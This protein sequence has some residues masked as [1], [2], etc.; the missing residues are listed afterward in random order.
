MQSFGKIAIWGAGDTCKKIIAMVKENQLGE[1]VAIADSDRR[2][3]GQL[4]SEGGRE[5]LSPIELQY[6]ILGKELQVDS[7]VF[8]IRNCFVE[9]ASAYF[10]FCDGVKGYMINPAIYFETTYDLS[11]GKDILL[12]IDFKKPRLDYLQIDLLQHCNMKCKSCMLYSNIIT[13]PNYADYDSVLNDWRRLKDLFWGVFKLR[14]LGGEPLLSPRL[15]DY[16]QSARQIFPDAEIEVVTNA[17]LLRENE[18]IENL[19]ELMCEENISFDISVYKPMEAKIDDVKDLLKKHGVKY[20][21]NMTKGEFYKIL[22]RNPDQNITVAHG[23][24]LSK[25]CHDLKEGRIYNCPRPSHISILN[26]KLQGKWPE[27]VGGYDLYS[28]KDGWQLKKVLNSPYEFCA[29]CGELVSNKWE[30]TDLSKVS[31]DDWCT[32]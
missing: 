18:E 3:Q 10:R 23:R 14:L 2:K 8:A 19:L 6:Q 11:A 12:Y 4:C 17:L 32:D 29:Y 16:V 13:E 1:I 27:K 26:E 15:A 25:K 24:C 21:L 28:A 30:R 7:I 5:V 9:D 22:R 20:S 31:L